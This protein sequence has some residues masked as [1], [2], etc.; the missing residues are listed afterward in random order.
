M[1]DSL[2]GPSHDQ[3]AAGSSNSMPAL[4]PKLATQDST[5]SAVHLN[6][7][8]GGG[9]GKKDEAAV[10]DARNAKKAAKKAAK[11]ARIAANQKKR[12]QAVSG[13][14]GKQQSAAGC[15]SRTSSEKESS[16][17]L[18]KST[19]KMP[20]FDKPQAY[21]KRM[22][23]AVLTRTQVQRQVAMFSHL[24]QYEKETSLS[25]QVGFS[26]E[27][28]IHPAILRLGLQYANGSIVGSN[29]RC[30]AM[31][32]GLKA[33]LAD[34]KQPG[35]KAVNRDLNQKLKPIIRFLE[36]CRPKS[37]SMGNAIRYVKQK[38]IKLP[39]NI[40]EVE[41]KH[42]LQQDI[43]RFIQL[44]IFFADQVIVSHGVKYIR[45]GDTILTYSKSHVV[46]M[47]LKHAH[48]EGIK[49][50]VIVADSRPHLEGK[51]LL[52]R[53]CKHGLDCT[54]TLVNSIGYVMSDVTKVFLGANSMLSNG[55]ALSRIGSSL[56]GMMAK[57]F[58]KPLIMCC[59][60]YK[61]HERVQVDSITFNELG[62]PDRLTLG[63]EQ[64]STKENV[65]VD[66]RD[67]PA[68]KMLNLKYDL[69]PQEF[70]QM[71]ITEIGIIPPSSV[72]V[73]VREY[74]TEVTGGV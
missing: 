2:S 57:E 55:T 66:W 40:G 46:E 24:I 73:V 13:D 25:L 21:A 56:I 35:D 20:T 52:D 17:H 69:V 31:L 34:Y 59:E 64:L 50:N 58:R 43:D 4:A 71:V 72:P 49:F 65:L 39:L 61:L 48:D 19:H 3:K 11:A 10:L 14:E 63:N 53:L 32:H 27:E 74:N 7:S 38:I 16:K 41:A 9:G 68:L 29:A 22:K 33:W 37:I 70:I 54:Y 28:K 18:Q 8:G 15:K 30:I 47:L 1:S 62:D 26:N 42:Q 51:L 36:D 44:R 60:T 12:D 67:I 5:L 23:G 6:K 45:D